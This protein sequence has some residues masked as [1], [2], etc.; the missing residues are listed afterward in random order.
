MIGLRKQARAL[1]FFLLSNPFVAV[2]DRALADER[3]AGGQSAQ[4][5]GGSKVCPECREGFYSQ[6][7]Q[8]LMVHWPKKNTPFFEQRRQTL[9]QMAPMK[10]LESHSSA[11]VT[12]VPLGKR[13]MVDAL[14]SGD[15]P[16]RV[17]IHQMMLI[18][19]SVA[20]V[21]TA[22]AKVE[23]YVR[24][25]PDLVSTQ[26]IEATPTSWLTE[27]V[28][29]PPVFFMPKTKY[30]LKYVLGDREGGLKTYRYQLQSGESLTES[31][32]F[33]VL[34]PMGAYTFFVEVDFF[35]ANWG[36]AKSLGGEQIWKH[37]LE[38]TLISDLALALRVENPKMS[39]ESIR[40][41]ASAEAAQTNFVELLTVARKLEDF[42][43]LK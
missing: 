8:N 14:R 11:P 24:L 21:A 37:S 38:S 26:L 9:V 28:Q 32:G 34:E 12:L 10:R 41:T 36:I 13:I 23:D 1:L 42:Y 5:P 18:H 19:A 43:E 30:R 31:D 40:S 39:F 35:N 7:L 4:K 29:A 25:F 2:G 15:D 33:I 20:E 3:Q 27:W 16:F 6:K 17:G 22:L